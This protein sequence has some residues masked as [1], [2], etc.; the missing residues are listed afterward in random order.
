MKI[1]VWILQWVGMGLAEVTRRLLGSSTQSLC[2]PTQI[3]E[4]VI[5][6]F[7]VELFIMWW[8]RSL[9]NHYPASPRYPVWTCQ[10]SELD[11]N[12]IRIRRSEMAEAPSHMFESLSTECVATVATALTDTPVVM[13]IGPRQC[14]LDYTRPSVRR[15][16]TPKRTPICHSGR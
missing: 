8:M 4:A 6:A 1:R 10:D 7:G 9:G 11:E 15:Q 14:G 12:L 2:A 16:R 5:L 13:L 3:G